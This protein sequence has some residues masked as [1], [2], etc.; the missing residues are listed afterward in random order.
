LLQGYNMSAPIFT[1]FESL[2]LQAEA[3]E[4]G[5]IAG[6][7]S[8]LYADAV[9]QSIIYMGGT[10]AD[11]DTYL[12]QPGKNLINYG[13]SPN[14]RAAILTQK[15]LA[16]NGISPMPIWTDYRRTGLPDFIHFTQDPATAN[17]TPPVRLLYP[18]T[19]ISTNNDNVVAQGTINLFSSKIFWQNR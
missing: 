12:S 5:L 4:R 10:S 8:V 6:N 18:Q 2:F 3:V 13:A 11:A 17:P 7:D 1:D 9:R 19:E 14:K 16:L 15:W